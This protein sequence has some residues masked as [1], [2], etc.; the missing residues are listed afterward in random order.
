[1]K[2]VPLLEKFHGKRLLL[3]TNLLLPYFMG[4]YYQAH[5]QVSRHGSFKEEEFQL[6]AQIVEYFRKVGNIL[7]TPHILTEV[8]NLGLKKPKGFKCPHCGKEINA[9]LSLRLKENR[10]AFMK[11]IRPWIRQLDEEFDEKRIGAC[12]LSGREY[13]PRF[14]LADAAIIELAYD[15]RLLILTDDEDLADHLKNQKRGQN[16]VYFGELKRTILD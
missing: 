12:R 4:S 9:G 6:L 8:S 11:F 3:D 1:M 13:F 10:V 7:T 2:V 16:V 5:Q 14:G 15:H